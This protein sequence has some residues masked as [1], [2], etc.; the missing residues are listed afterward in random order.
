M[1]RPASRFRV[2]GLGFKSWALGV[3]VRCVLGFEVQGSGF[4]VQGCGF[5]VQGFGWFRVQGVGLS[6]V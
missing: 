4:G 1:S 3:G 6:V 5:R 2:N